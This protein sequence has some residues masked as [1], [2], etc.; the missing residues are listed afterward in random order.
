MNKTFR[1]FLDEKA[2]ESPAGERRR[3]RDEWIN[4]VDRLLG[5]IEVWLREADPDARLEFE[6]L[7]EKRLESGIGEYEVSSLR[8]RLGDAQ[9][10][11][12]PVARNVMGLVAPPG[13][14]G[15]AIRAEGRV[16]ISCRG[17]K[18]HLY[19]IIGEGEDQWYARG[20][21]LGDRRLTSDL[22]LEIVQDLMS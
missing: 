12:K 8:I 15:E 3:R 13:T 1:E 5:Q 18:Y 11:V 6:H 7:T 17:W 21:K 16:D 22:L 2:R 4:A 14:V 9:I 10:D 19:R 20:E